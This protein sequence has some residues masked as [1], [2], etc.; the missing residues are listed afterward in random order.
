MPLQQSI[1]PRSLAIFVVGLV[2]TIASACGTSAAT[3]SDSLTNRPQPSSLTPNQIFDSFRD[4][5][6]SSQLQAPAPAMTE[7]KNSCLQESLAMC[8]A[9]TSAVAV[10]RKCEHEFLQ[11]AE[12]ILRLGRQVE[13]DSGACTIIF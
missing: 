9:G 13:C 3:P 6:I 7:S 12:H 11:M 5:I 2:G 4:C 1:C 8:S 10:T